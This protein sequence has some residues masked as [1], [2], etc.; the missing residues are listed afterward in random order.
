[1]IKEEI[2]SL[3]ALIIALLMIVA[4]VLLISFL[5]LLRDKYDRSS[6]NESV[7]TYGECY[8]LCKGDSG[9]EPDDCIGLCAYGWP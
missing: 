5:L 8:D 2:M 1:M 7:P 6:A 9:G 3:L 4:G